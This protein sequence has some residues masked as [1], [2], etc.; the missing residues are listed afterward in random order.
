[1]GIEEVHIFYWG[2]T[3]YIYPLEDP[4]LDERY[5]LKSVSMEQ[6]GGQGIIS[7]VLEWD[8]PSAL[9]KALMKISVP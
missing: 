3:W 2:E 8:R 6:N 4:S 7:V 5:V 9:V 1:M